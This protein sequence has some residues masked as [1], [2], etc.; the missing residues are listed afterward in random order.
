VAFE[1]TMQSWLVDGVGCKSKARE[2]RHAQV[3]VVGREREFEP[4]E[5][6]PIVGLRVLLGE[7][8]KYLGG[9]LASREGRRQ[10]NP[11]SVAVTVVR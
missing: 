4:V 9:I 1:H 11:R 10:S 2:L 6:L 5:E 7:L 3:A 8:E